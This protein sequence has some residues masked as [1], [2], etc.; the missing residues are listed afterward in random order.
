MNTKKKITGSIRFIKPGIHT[1]LQDEGRTGYQHVGISPSGAADKYAF[2]W[3]NKL[4]GNQLNQTAIE[5]F[6]GNVQLEF[7]QNCYVAITGAQVDIKLNNTS[8][9]NWA[10]F[11]VKANDTLKIGP[12]KSGQINYVALAGA[13]NI[14]NVLGSQSINTREGI[15]PNQ[16]M[17][18]S[19]NQTLDFVYNN[20]V[21]TEKSAHWDA[22]PDYNQPLKLHFIPSTTFL[23]IDPEIQKQF[24]NAEF[25]VSQ[26][27]NKLG[28]RLLGPTIRPTF[29]SSYSEPVT[30]GTIQL[31]P[32]GQPIVL[33][34]D[35]QTIGGYPKLGTV[36]RVDCWRLSQRQSRQ[37]VS[38]QTGSIEAAQSEYINTMKSYKH[39][40]HR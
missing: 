37:I 10:S 25:T 16:G 39:L 35:R 29:E 13:Y 22:I 27:S 6:L 18:F 3:A 15:G 8:K 23:Q 28:K 17:A 1:T 31:P 40:F 36:Y 4:A 19:Q 21:K 11:N 2:Y 14:Q 24:L 20:D 30:E 9:P 5:I 7:S 33:L 26:D 12:S 34:S 38:F 32:N